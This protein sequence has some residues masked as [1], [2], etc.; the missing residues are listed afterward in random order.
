MLY[1]AARIPDSPARELRHSSRGRGTLGDRASVLSGEPWPGAGAGPFSGK[2]AGVDGLFLAGRSAV[3]RGG[4]CPPGAFRRGR[5]HLPA[6]GWKP[7]PRSGEFSDRSEGPMVVGAT[8][9]RRR[10][11]SKPLSGNR[12]G[13]R[14][15]GP[16]LEV[17]VRRGAGSGPYGHPCTV[18][19]RREAAHRKRWLPGDP[20]RRRGTSRRGAYRVSGARRPAD[21]RGWPL[22]PGGSNA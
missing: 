18:S 10:R 12:H 8:L 9:V 11:V 16:E 3:R 22:C 13:L 15:G 19:R 2:S 5:P 6:G 1:G 14:R 20:I 7:P 21:C 4:K 17:R